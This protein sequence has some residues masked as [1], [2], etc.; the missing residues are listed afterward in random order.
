MA[1]NTAHVVGKITRKGVEMKESR[2]CKGY[3]V[4]TIGLDMASDFSRRRRDKDSRPNW[5]FFRVTAFGKSGEELG[6]CDAGDTVEV[7]GRFEIDTYTAR[8]GSERTSMSIFAGA[9]SAV[10]VEEDRDRGQNHGG[11][12]E[13]AS[14]PAANN[15]GDDD[16]IPF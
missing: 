14:A 5:S 6:R 1:E 3:A 7:M 12:Y 16:D 4:C 8:D 10:R 9:L 2:N 11:G 13:T 15:G